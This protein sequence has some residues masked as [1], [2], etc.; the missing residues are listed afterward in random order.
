MAQDG[1][2]G[3]SPENGH[4]LKGDYHELFEFKPGNFRF[5]GFPHA[6]VFYIANGA[7]KDEKRQYKDW[8]FAIRLRIEF[9]DNLS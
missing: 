4:W 1:K 6:R 3:K 5:F 2:L 7:G 8:N 9:F